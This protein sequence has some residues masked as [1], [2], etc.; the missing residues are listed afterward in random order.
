MNFSE[1]LNRQTVCIDKVSKS[2]TAVFLKIS[3]LLASDSNTLNVETLFDAYWR[4]ENLGSTAIGHG[5]LIP[6]IRTSDLSH[7]KACF[8]KLEHQ[9]DFGA[10]DKQPIDLVFGL[11]VPENQP[12]EHLQTLKLIIQSFSQNNSRNACR[13]CENEESLFNLLTNIDSLEL[14]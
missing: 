13:L 9:V 8:I 1:L 2:K 11:I 10:E 6:H 5:I 3:Q 12:E 4:R 14:A 7:I